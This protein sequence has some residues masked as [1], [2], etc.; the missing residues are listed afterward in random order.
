MRATLADVAR[1]VVEDEQ[2]ALRDEVGEAA[3]D[4]RHGER[5]DQRVDAEHGDDEAVDEA[6]SEAGADRRAAIA[7]AV[8]S[9]LAEV[10]GDDGRERVGRADR[11]V[12]AAGDE[13][14]RP[15]R[16]DDQRRRLLV[17][18]VEQVGARRER[19]SSSAQSTT[20]R[21]DERDQDPEAAQA[22]SRRRAGAPAS[23]ARRGAAS[24]TPPPTSSAKAARRIAFSVIASPA[25]S[26]TIRPRAHDEDAVGEA[27]HL[28]ELG[29][30]Q[31]HAAAVGGE[32]GQEVV[33]RALG[34]D[35]DAARR[36]VGDQHVRLAEQ[37][38]REQ[39]L[40]LVAARER[41]TGR[42]VVAPRTSQRSSIA[43]AG[44]AARGRGGRRRAR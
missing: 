37:R 44:A 2:V 5:R 11:E 31:D 29:R 15:G 27:E 8:P 32:L 30:D 33:D 22:R 41:R 43:R 25:S 6:D 14:E 39:H 20:K 42:R 1:L 24:L 12:D 23:D 3:D 10:R 40:L 9:V 28:L 38:P 34:A 21:S 4:E 19:A 26:A 13:H 36:L 16:R 17:E 35:V 7:D 18:D